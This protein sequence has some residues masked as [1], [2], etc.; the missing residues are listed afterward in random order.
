MPPPATSWE[1]LSSLY[2]GFIFDQFGV[3]HNGAAALD[4]AP[5]LVARLA[6]AGKKLGILSNSSKRKE[7]TLRELPKLGFSADAFVAAAVTTSGEEAWHALGAHWRGKACVWLSKRDGDGVTDYLEGTGVGL[8]CVERADF[9]LCSGTNVIRDGEGVVSV[10]CEATGDVA[11]YAALFSRALERGLPMLCANP[12]FVSPPKPGKATTYQPG[13]L[14]AHYEGLGGTVLYYGKPH[15]QH[16]EACVAGLGLPRERV[17]HVGDSMH[18]DVAGAVAASVPVIFVAGGIEH[19][20]L[21]ISPGELPAPEALRRLA[22]THG[23]ARPTHTVALA[24][25]DARGMSGT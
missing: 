23:G 12:D 20:E 10:D 9:L 7:W 24:R 18:H 13:H 4:G 1:Q 8:A 17:A 14:A 5:A 22:E 15:A 21:G 16:F 6:A 2:D 11:P 19:E 3:M 25:W